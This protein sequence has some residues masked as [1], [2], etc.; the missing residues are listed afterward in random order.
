MLLPL[1]VPGCGGDDTGG[2]LTLPPSG[3]AGDG[4][5]KPDQSAESGSSEKD[6]RE[7]GPE[8]VD[9]DGGDAALDTTPPTPDS[10]TPDA[11]TNDSP[12]VTV[13][14]PAAV[15]ADAR[16]PAESGP[17]VVDAGTVDE[18]GTSEAGDADAAADA[19]ST[20]DAE[21]AAAT[22]ADAAAVDVAEDAPADGDAADVN[23]DDGDACTIDTMLADGACSHI[24]IVCVALDQCHVAGTCTDGVCSNPDKNDG[25][26]CNDD[27]ACTQTDS[28][29]SGK[30]TGSNPVRCAAPDGCHLAGRCN[31]S[32]G[33]CEFP[34]LPNNTNCDDG[35]ACTQTDKCVDGVCTGTDPILCAALDQCH[36]AGVCSGGICSNPNKPDNDPCSDGDAC[37]QTDTCIN[38]VCTGTNP[39]V[40]TALDQ[41]HLAGVCSGGV[42]SNPKRA[43]NDP[44]SDGDACTQTDKCVDGVCTGTNPVVCTALDQCHVA[45]VCT[46][47]ICSNPDKNDGD[48]CDDQNKCT[49]TDTCQSGVCTGGNPKVCTADECHDPGTCDPGTGDC[50]AETASAPGSVCTSIAG[51]RCATGACVP[52]FM[53]VRVGDGSAPLTTAATAV[54]LERHYLDTVGALIETIPIPT[55]VDGNNQPLTMNGTAISEGVLTRS[56]DNKYVT[57]AGYAAIPGT[58]GPGPLPVQLAI[59][60][61]TAASVHRVVGRVSADGTV[62]TS[63]QMN[64]AFDKNNVRGATSTNGSDIW[65]TGAGAVTGGVQYV[66]FGSSGASTLLISPGGG[67]PITTR[68]P[69]IFGNQLY[70]TS[71]GNFAN[72][73]TLGGNPPP[74][75]GGQTPVVL[76]GMPTTTSTLSPYSFQLFDTN[77]DG[78]F[79]TLYIADERAPNVGGGVQKWL[80]AATA[81]DGGIANLWTLSATFTASGVRGLVGMKIGS[82]IHLIATSADASANKILYFIDDGTPNPTPTVLATSATVPGDGG[83]PSAATLYRGVAL[84]P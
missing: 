75:T 20:P 55:A 65:V 40:C 84:G 60:A 15:D 68:V 29:Q 30:C 14:S 70:F 26:P 24:P 38:G 73:S 33:V 69:L 56:V 27:N 72:V 19:A 47:G 21:E 71:S 17:D 62:D 25:S 23:C 80:L 53:V 7:T 82:N 11:T 79:D 61:S 9:Q 78:A 77:G 43:D 45:G 35:D 13:D 28:C 76:P 4:S 52:T 50:S 16:A 32:D 41:C 2:P 83:A 5:A 67:N 58:Q 44:C 81:V 6:A 51:G 57:L 3:D 36:L 10:T 66:Q 39:V 31:T 54:F 34:N 48:P 74:N 64:N 46:G 37:T 22:D 8:P 42:C 63:T 18:T 1:I 12:D 59:S 49:Q